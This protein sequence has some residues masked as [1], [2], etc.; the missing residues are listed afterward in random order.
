MTYRHT[1]IVINS[2]NIGNKDRITSNIANYK[3]TKLKGSEKC[4]NCQESG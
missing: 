2:G 3:I 1:S 4:N